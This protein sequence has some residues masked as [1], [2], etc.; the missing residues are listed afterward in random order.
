MTR[1]ET[2]VYHILSQKLNEKGKQKKTAL[3][4]KTVQAEALS[5]Q[6]AASIGVGRGRVKGREGWGKL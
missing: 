2:I 4:G 1:T 3:Q 6:M 5:K